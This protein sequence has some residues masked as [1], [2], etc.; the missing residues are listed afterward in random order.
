M[1]QSA[2]PRGARPAIQRFLIQHD[3]DSFNPR[4]HA[5]RDKLERQHPYFLQPFQSARPRGARPAMA[6][7]RPFSAHVSIRAPTRGATAYL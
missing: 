3:Y 6:Q 2:R 7:Y 5:G 1:F 4:A